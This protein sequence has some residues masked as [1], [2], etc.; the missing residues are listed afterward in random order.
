[1][2]RTITAFLGM[3]I[4]V[5]ALA[6]PAAAAP[7]TAEDGHLGNIVEEL[8]ELNAETGRYD[9]LIEAVLFAA[10]NG[11]DLLTPLSTVD[12]L[13]LFAPTDYAFV[14]L[15]RE[16]TGDNSIRQ[17]AAFGVIAG[18]LVEAGGGL[19]GAVELL[20]DTLTYHVA[21]VVINTRDRNKGPGEW[22][23]LNGDT[24]YV[25]GFMVADTADRTGKIFKGRTERASNGRIYTTNIV[26]LPNSL[27]GGAS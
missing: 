7:E 24:L 12:G 6:A 16:L 13:T 17:G 14:K 20:A 18:V 25:R 23:M 3:A 1:M 26:V 10:D 21:P 4:M 15:A 11:V 2:R 9:I 8:L 19:D 27:T 5:T 22:E